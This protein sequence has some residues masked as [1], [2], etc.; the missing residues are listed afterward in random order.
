ME[1]Q[2]SGGC[3]EALSL[4]LVIHRSSSKIICFFLSLFAI[5]L[6][7]ENNLCEHSSEIILLLYPVQAID[8]DKNLCSSI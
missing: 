7:A 1:F 8:Y 4:S 6:V 3:I 2:K 5:T